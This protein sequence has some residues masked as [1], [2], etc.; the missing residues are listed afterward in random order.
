[1]V[2]NRYS[3]LPVVDLYQRTIAE[4]VAA[5][6]SGFH[7]VAVTFEDTDSPLIVQKGVLADSSPA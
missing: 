1:M 2:L 4:G 3:Q 6:F 7:H 5:H